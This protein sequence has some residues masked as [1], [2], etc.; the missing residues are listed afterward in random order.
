[1]NL[2]QKLEILNKKS[3]RYYRAIDEQVFEL[4][5]YGSPELQSFSTA[6]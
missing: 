1:M 4:S 3:V 5:L 2:Q 6:F